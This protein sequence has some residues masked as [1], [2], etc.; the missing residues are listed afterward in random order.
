MEADLKKLDIKGD[1][2]AFYLT[3]GVHY[4]DVIDCKGDNTK[5]VEWND[6]D[7]E[8][9]S[10]NTMI[11][12]LNEEEE[13]RMY[14]DFDYQD[15]TKEEYESLI[16]SLDDLIKSCGK[17]SMGGYTNSEEY[18]QYGFKLIPDAKKK[19]SAH[20]VFYD[21]CVNR[22]DFHKIFSHKGSKLP[23][24]NIPFNCDYDVYKDAGK[25]QKFR[26]TLSNK[27]FNKKS[28][29]IYNA[30]NMIKGHGFENCITSSGNETYK[31]SYEDLEKIFTPRETYRKKREIKQYEIANAK[32]NKE[33]LLKQYK[34]D[35]YTGTDIE[36]S[37]ELFN[38]IMSYFETCHKTLER[39]VSGCFIGHCPCDKDKCEEI[40]SSW[41][42]AD[43]G[44]NTEYDH[45]NYKKYMIYYNN[46][47]SNNW[48][49]YMCSKIEDKNDKKKMMNKF[50][51]GSI[52]CENTLI[53]VNDKS[54]SYE[55]IKHF[56]YGV[57][58]FDEALNL[59]RRVFATNTEGEYYIKHKDPKDGTIYI[60]TLR[61]D[62]LQKY[63]F[64]PVQG[65]MI[66][67]LLKNYYRCFMTNG[68]DKSGKNLKNYTPWFCGYGWTKQE[69]KEESESLRLFKHHCELLLGDNMEAVLK[70]FSIL[71]HT[72]LIKI[73]VMPILVGPK[74][75]GKTWMINT[76]AHLF[77]RYGLS[78]A[79]GDK[80]FHK[81]ADNTRFILIHVD[82]A[83]KESKVFK[84]NMTDI[85]NL[86][87]AEKK[88]T[89]IKKENIKYGA[90]CWANF[91]LST[92]NKDFM[93]K[94]IAAEY[95]RRFWF[96]PTYATENKHTNYKYWTTLRKAINDAGNDFYNELY[97]WI[98]N[99]Y[100]DDTFNL[101]QS[102]PE[103]YNDTELSVRYEALNPIKKAI[104]NHWDELEK[105]E[106][107]FVIDDIMD[108]IRDEEYHGCRYN[109]A[110]LGREL[111]AMCDVDR[112]KKSKVL[113]SVR[114]HK[115][116]RDTKIYKVNKEKMDADFENLYKY[117]KT[118]YCP[119][120]EDDEEEEEQEE[121]K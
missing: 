41:W 113:L 107:G 84:D 85:Q 105:S 98:Y 89:E 101:I 43:N 37:Q 59:C 46:D 81:Y 94:D 47:N 88:D 10:K 35:S 28:D 75:N 56:T 14:F 29:C 66:S 97:N 99:M 96:V 57:E 42:N 60:D 55:D 68:I 67:T 34:D 82:E 53:D 65:I 8:W 74:G 90:Y 25:K 16:K 52:K 86:I 120:I 70:W 4:V 32:S 6:L 110:T 61:F 64:K 112:Y 116:K 58:C 54:I 78:P 103:K 91:I 1:D 69:Y 114:E 108:Y 15:I 39:V 38:E 44:D 71:L 102:E 117:A 33:T 77:G 18:A 115:I 23:S 121:E 62:Q 93:P 80:V 9:F 20:V 21:C 40:V 19:L 7:D 45:D 12:I 48:Y 3:D 11:E 13:S 51:G 100:D 27:M 79:S 109:N 49:Y 104:Y 87:T 5:F 118:V 36:F 72:P 31:L 26:H 106:N 73:G 92:N 119:K 50:G 83:S 111:N 76:I 30:G 24:H 95:E 22:T 17:Y 63:T 2:R